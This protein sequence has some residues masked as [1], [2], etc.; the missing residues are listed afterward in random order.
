MRR[1][2]LRGDT[3]NGDASLRIPIFR[4]LS[5]IIIAMKTKAYL[6][7]LLLSIAF[8]A[9]CASSDRTQEQKPCEGGASAVKS[10]TA[11]ERLSQT[12][13]AFVRGAK[14]RLVCLDLDATLCQHRTTP[15]P[16]NMAALGEL[17]KR[18]KCIMVGAGNAPRIHRQMGGYPIDILANYGMQEAKIVDG[19][20]TIV[21]QETNHVDRAFFLRETDRLRRKYGY[22]EYMGNPVEFHASGMVTFGLLGTAPAAEHKVTFDPDRA[23]RRAI[24][25]EVCKIFKDYSVFIGGSTSFDFAG[26]KNN[27]YDC[28]MDYAKREGYVR[29]EIIFIGDDFGDGGGDSHVRIKGMDYIYV[30]DYR[31]FP[32]R[33]ACL[34]K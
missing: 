8:I 7:G 23:K 10:V 19:K 21:R 31:K 15:P 6:S 33:V 11:D 32:E 30:D 2:S 1:A 12:A 27:K 17:Q 22:T 29:D 13:P 24:Y 34:L 26:P 20:F 4:V 9:A 3:K 14:K 25:P 5:A 28:I 16:E 18:Y